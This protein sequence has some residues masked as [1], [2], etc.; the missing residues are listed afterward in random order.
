[1]GRLGGFKYREVARK[2]KSLG[3]QF[4][5][6]GAGSHEV[7]RHSTNGMVIIVP[8]IREKCRKGR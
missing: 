6:Q 7:W 4:A 5:R 8:I 2:L 1:M 3:Y